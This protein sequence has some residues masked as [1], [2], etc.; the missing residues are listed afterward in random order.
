MPRVHAAELRDV[1]LWDA[2][3]STRIVLDVSAAAKSH[4]FTLGNPDRVVI[5]LD[6]MNADAIKKADK[7]EPKCLVKTVRAGARGDGIRSVLDVGQPVMATEVD[8]APTSNYGNRVAI[9]IG[10]ASCR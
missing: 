5:D 10:R 2:P 1:R 7:A 6:D 9:E 8:L 4:V 3:D